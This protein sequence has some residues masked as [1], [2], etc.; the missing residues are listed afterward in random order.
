MGRQ[1]GRKM[2]TGLLLIDG[3]GFSEQDSRD[4]SSRRA[5]G[6]VVVLLSLKACFGRALH[7]RSLATR[8]ATQFRL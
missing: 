8:F 6:I 7:A 4:T 2:G 1:R 3:G 5:T